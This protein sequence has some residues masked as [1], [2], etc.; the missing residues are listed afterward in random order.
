M[1][2]PN[3]YQ[4]FVSTQSAIAV[5]YQ[6]GISETGDPANGR[7][8]RDLR[9]V[10]WPEGNRIDLFWTTPGDVTRIVIKRSLNAHSAFLMDDTQV[11]YDGPITD[12]FIDG[13]KVSATL[14]DPAFTQSPP[15]LEVGVPSSGEVLLPDKYYY[16]TIYMTAK[17]GPV[18]VFDFGLEAMSMCQVT[19]LSILNFLLTQEGKRWYGEYFYNMFSMETRD[20]DRA[21][22]SSQGLEYG[23]FQLF[24][25]FIQG[26]IN[27]LRGNARAIHQIADVD[28]MP[29]GLVGWAYMQA[30]F[31]A[32]RSRILR[33]NPERYILNPAIMRRLCSSL[34]FLYKEKGT[35]PGLVDFVKTVTLWDSSCE[36]FEPGSG[37][38]NLTYLRTYDGY[39]SITR[40][41]RQSSLITISAGSLYLPGAGLEVDAHALSVFTTSMWE[42]FQI[43]SNTEDTVTL[44]DTTAVPRVED[45]LTISAVN[46]ISGTL[47]ELICTRTAGGPVL[48]NDNEY[49][50][51]Y[52]LDSDN[53]LLEVVTTGTESLVPGSS[54]IVVNSTVTP[55]T[56]NASAALGFVLGA[57]FAARDPVVSFN[58]HTHCPTFL[59]DPLMDADILDDQGVDVV[60]P[61]DIL[62]SGGSLI[63]TPFV[64]GDTILTIAT[65]VAKFVGAST[66]ISGN[67]LTD[68]AANFGPNLS[69]E[70]HFLN[71]NRNQKGT[72]RIVSNTT[73][74]LTVESSIPG[75][76][77][78]TVSAAGS[79][80]YVL[81]FIEHRYYEV[82]RRLI[83][84]V[85]TPIS[86]R[87][88]IFFEGP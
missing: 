45:L 84:D 22:A 5:V 10:S 79:Q 76:T 81:P 87:V 60:N 18:G 25:R 72:F 69:N 35:C 83:D 29:A 68:T 26:G 66:S 28:S 48:L 47:Y 1:F 13:V 74:T 21:I 73:T 54:R 51:M 8:P 70:Y 32:S 77:L 41:E 33:I 78:E 59:Y 82:L 37:P 64:P 19:G 49:D 67:T 52:V 80:Y 63:G 62:F 61:H 88:F 31:L 15:E 30:N 39:D 46:A 85:F 57:N 42:L 50:N 17:V 40:V 11:I 86:T 55:V 23:W 16:Y 75:V 4:Q 3:S 53:S 56:G 58:L 38:C 7:C 2:K 20:R 44:V 27:I 12:H 6:V 14:G 65:G 71:P 34:I 9:A 43:Q 24:C 36:E